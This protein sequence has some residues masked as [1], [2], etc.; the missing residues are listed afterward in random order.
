[1]K[2]SKTQAAPNAQ[3]VPRAE[4]EDMAG[5][6][7]G[8]HDVI[9]R[10]KETIRALAEMAGRQGLPADLLRGN[11]LAGNERIEAI[12]KHLDAAVAAQSGRGVRGDGRHRVWMRMD[13]LDEY[14]QNDRQL[15]ALTLLK[16]MK[17]EYI[18]YLA[19]EYVETDGGK[20]YCDLKMRSS[21]PENRSKL[22]I[23]Y[24][25]FMSFFAKRT[26]LV[27]AVI[28]PSLAWTGPPWSGRQT[29]LTGRL[30]RCCPA[31]PPWEGSWRPSRAATSS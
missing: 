21:D 15:H 19:E 3:T 6:Y 13:I 9:G 11:V 18:A 28:G 14:I 29:S 17:F 23:R 2:D 8:A 25:I 20:P 4:Y 22:K 10:Q 7:A 26:N 16:S 12:E 30:R 27:P 31:S 1:M 24:I 5:K